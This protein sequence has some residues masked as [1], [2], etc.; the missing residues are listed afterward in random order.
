MF[1]K[2]IVGLMLLLANSKSHA[3]SCEDSYRQAYLEYSARTDQHE[4]MPEDVQIFLIFFDHSNQINTA[5]LEARP[6]FQMMG[7]K[8]EQEV[9]I[10]T[11]LNRQMQSG[12]LC[13]NFGYTKNLAQV[14][15]GLR[16]G[17]NR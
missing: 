11:E 9:E 10:L 13:G 14:A 3:Q 8:P 7:A 16:S 6:L 15:E 1:T 5:K 17:L 4:K 2:S 12:A